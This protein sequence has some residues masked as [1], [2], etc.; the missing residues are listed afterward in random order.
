MQVYDVFYTDLATNESCY[1][2]VTGESEVQVRSLV[3]DNFGASVRVDS[4]TLV[5]QV[6]R[7][8]EVFRTDSG[9]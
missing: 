2:P 1:I 9:C 8:I 3:S 7:S 4:V 6:L 5:D